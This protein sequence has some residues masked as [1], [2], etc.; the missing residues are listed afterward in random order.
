MSGS[1]TDSNGSS[2]TEADGAG[3][4][5]ATGAMAQATSAATMKIECLIAH[6]L[7]Y[8]GHGATRRTEGERL[9]AVSDSLFAAISIKMCAAGDGTNRDRNLR[10]VERAARWQ[11]ANIEC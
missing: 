9:S 6:I 10:T 1:G 11:S 3:V 5:V 7:L 4:C 2:G 8:S